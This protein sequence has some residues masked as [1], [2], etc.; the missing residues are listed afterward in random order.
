L[1][2][3]F[4]AI[5][6]KLP[7]P[8]PSIVLV[9]SDIVGFGLIDH[10][11]PLEVTEAPPSDVT[12]PPNEAVVDVIILTLDVTTVGTLQETTLIS[13]ETDCMGQ[14]LF[15]P[16]YIVIVVVPVFF[17]VKIRLNIFPDLKHISP[18]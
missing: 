13:L 15:I 11:I 7:V 1:G 5:E 16:L 10:T 2:I 18:G 9:L 17:P 4:V 12:F 8:V 3:K 6:L 14:L